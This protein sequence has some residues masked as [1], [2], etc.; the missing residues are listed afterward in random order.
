VGPGFAPARQQGVER[1]AERVE[2]HDRLRPV[3]IAAGSERALAMLRHGVSRQGHDRHLLERRVGAQTARDLETVD[4]ARQA[5]IHQDEVGRP[6]AQTGL[7]FSR[8][9]RRRYPVAPQA[10]TH[11]EQVANVDVVFN[12]Q[13]VRHSTDRLRARSTCRA[14]GSPVRHE[15][16]APA[17]RVRDPTRDPSQGPGQRR[18]E[19]GRFAG[20]ARRA[21]H[22]Q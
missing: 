5:Q 3:G 7:H 6:C 2:I 15:Q 20:C 13:Y 18:T 4:A 12:H 11:A 8:I 16:L 9:A 14:G 19:S 1:C 21:R 17:R 22:R 10:E